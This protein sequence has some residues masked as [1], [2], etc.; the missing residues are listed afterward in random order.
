MT[1]NSDYRSYP[2]LTTKLFI[3]KLRSATIHR[4]RLT[5]KLDNGLESKLTLVCAPAGF[6]KT[7]LLVD[8]ISKSTRPV[9]WVSLDQTEN[10]PVRFFK[11]LT[12]ALQTIEKD[13]GNSTRSMLDVNEGFPIESFAANL[14]SDISEFKTDFLLILDDFHVID[15]PNVYKAAEFI[16]DNM[17][18]NMHLVISSRVDPPFPITRMKVQNQVTEI[19]PV[20]L[21]F[22]LEE[23]SSFYNEIMELNLKDREIAVMES[24]TE[25]WIAGL[26]LAGISMKGNKDISGFIDAFAG[27]NRHVV[28]YLAEEVLNRQPDHIQQFLFQSSILSRFCAELCDAVT[29]RNDSRIILEELERINLFLIPLDD[30]RLWFRYHH[31]FGELMRQRL[32]EKYPDTLNDLNLKASHWFEAQGEM[33]DAVN[34]AVAAD[35]YDRAADLIETYVQTDWQGREQIRLL[36]WLEKIPSQIVYTRP[37]LWLVQNRILLEGGQQKVAKKNLDRLEADLNSLQNAPFDITQEESLVYQGK[38]AAIRAHIATTRGDI[39]GIEKF[40]KKALDLLPKKDSACRATVALSSGIAQNIKGDAVAGVKAHSEAAIAAK[41]AGNVYLHLIAR[42]WKIIDLKDIGQLPEASKICDE[43]LKEI[44]ENKLSFNVAQ[45]HV[46]GVRGE[47]LYEMNKLEEA[48]Q[49]AK[50]GVSNLQH[51]HD[52]SHLGWR[53]T[54]LIKILCSRQKVNEAHDLVFN[55]DHLMK[56]VPIPPWLCSQIKAVKARV[57]LMQGHK[58][59]LLK[60]IGDH[61]L[62]VDWEYTVLREPENI[63]HARILLNQDRLDDALEVTDRLLEVQEKDSRVLNQIETLIIKSSIL[64]KMQRKTDSSNTLVQAL[65]LAQPG[66]YLRVFVDEGPPLA[67]LIET[68]DDFGKKSVKE[69]TKKLL[70]EFK[71][72]K[73]VIYPGNLIEPLSDRELEV[74]RLLSAGLSNKTITEE[75]FISSNTVKTHLKNIYSKL[76][77]HS[78]SE[79]IIKAQELDLL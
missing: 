78:R 68:I 26:Q 34:H 52:V 62:K 22:N 57:L 4:N 7:T 74:L 31:L 56:T 75:L 45:G 48:E 20:D 53:L 47:L 46:N 42:L 41:G 70:V 12:G 37:D 27:D 77:V 25:G 38:I 71:T 35:C 15:N 24:K 51:G 61:G 23:I 32:V 69:F 16:L 8:W 64:S 67:M 63:M 13:L 2:L 30:K 39:I 49:Y 3:P 9:A 79:A 65:T 33:E 60:W 29:G 73:Q 5:E 11:Y 21:S 28:D 10:D 14:I 54:C 44:D 72:R 55:V 36:K 18:E 76:S 17:P 66:G 58:D 43:L 19:R 40:C 59:K 6:G 1:I 50:I